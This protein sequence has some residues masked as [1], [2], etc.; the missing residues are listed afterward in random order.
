MGLCECDLCRMLTYAWSRKLEVLLETN[1]SEEFSAALAANTDIV[2]INNRNLG[3][4]K[5]DIN[6]TGRI[7]QQHNP[8]GK[9]IISESGIKTPGDIRL[10]YRWGARGF[11]IGSE[12]MCAE[13]IEEKV[14]EFVMALG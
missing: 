5:V 4:L 11:L 9:V 1:T 14:R 7:L 10:L 6:M 8:D 2:G 12:V 3:N 13:N